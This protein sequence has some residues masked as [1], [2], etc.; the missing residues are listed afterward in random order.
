M[1]LGPPNTQ[2]SYLPPELDFT[3]DERLF[4][5]LVSKRERLTA[6]LLNV[7]ENAQYEKRELLSGQ[8][9]F[10]Q[11]V[12]GAT[13]TNYVYRISFDLTTFNAPFLP[14]VPVP[15]GVTTFTL[16]ASPTVTQPTSINIPTNI[17]PVHGFGAAI[18]GTNFFFINDPLLFVRTNIW[19]N[20]L[21]QVIVTNNTG[22]PLTW[23]VWVMEYIKT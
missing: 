15:I 13:K 4:R 8:Q 12:S 1:T 2:S 18:N 21:Q 3:V 7:K 14:R 16:N 22:A 5:E 9:W 10:S 23:C 11:Q 17:F 20:A 19:T 6:T